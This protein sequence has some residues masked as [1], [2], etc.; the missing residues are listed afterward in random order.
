LPKKFSQINFL[1][2]SSQALPG[3]AKTFAFTGTMSTQY[4]STASVAKRWD[5]SPDLIRK[6][7]RNGAIKAVALTSGKRIRY[8]IAL[9]TLEQYENKMGR[10]PHAIKEREI[11]PFAIRFA[12]GEN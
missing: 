6:L 1:A 3:F 8:R 12:R 7:V 4:L 11:S 9:H 2:E 10:V 5:C